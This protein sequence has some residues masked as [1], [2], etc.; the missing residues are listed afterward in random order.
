MSE[1][2]NN[3]VESVHPA[4]PTCN[5]IAEDGSDKVP[6]TETTV[7]EADGVL[8]GG[9]QTKDNGNV[10]IEGL[11]GD[12]NPIDTTTAKEAAY[13]VKNTIPM[14]ITFTSQYAIQIL[15]SVLFAS[16]LGPVYASAATLSLTVFYLTGP[17]IF[18]GFSTALDTM[19]STAYGARNYEKVGLYYQK[20]TLILLL[21]LIP[22]T[23]IYENGSFVFGIISDD[24]EVVAL[25]AQFFRW[26]PLAAPAVVIFETSKRFLQSQQKFSAPTR[27]IILALALSLFLN[28]KLLPV[29]HFNGPPVTFVITYWFMALSLLAY[30]YF[31]DGYQCWCCTP[32]ADLF[33]GWSAFFTLGVPG[34]LMILSESLA[35]TILTFFSARMGPDQL[36]A[37]SVVGTLA[38]FAFNVPF[39]SAIC[40]ATRTANIIGSCSANYTVALPVMMYT[41]CFFSVFNFIWMVTFRY[42]IA[43]QF[44]STPE[45]IHLIARIFTIVGF[46][47]FL[48]CFNIICASILR[49]QGRQRLG[50]ILSIFSYYVI[51]V[52][53][54]LLFGFRMGGNDFGLWLGLAIGVSFLS[55][56]E[57]IVVLRSDWPAIIKANQS[58]T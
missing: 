47:Q 4:T 32:F 36:A 45:L 13:I 55:I 16:K 3:G 51:A 40:C 39:S 27:I 43:R 58:M 28:C 1:S 53:F 46:N 57:V 33:T 56:T 20:C 50:S 25:C 24:P 41:A 21:I 35:F 11:Y 14:L 26:I 18:N 44:A 15:N 17:V 34:V 2:D 37:Q 30:I 42:P 49:G 12:L 48:D 52:P 5:V 38:S 10:D 54:E 23:V 7:L 22:I 31:I 19:C 9:R 29:L 6:T 8:Y